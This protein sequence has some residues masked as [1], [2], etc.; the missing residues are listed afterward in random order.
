MKVTILTVGS[1]GDVQ[2]FI[3][4]GMGL[5][6]AGHEVRFCTSHN[7]EPFV[8][9]HGLDYA[10]MDD[11][12]IQLTESPEARAAMEKGGNPLGLIKKVKPMIKKM[13]YDQW[14]AVQGTEAIIYHPKTL[15]GYHLM[16]KLNVPG[17]MAIFVPAYTPTAEF[18]NP[19]LTRFSLGGWFNKLTYKLM[20]LVQAPYM[21]VV[22][23]WRQ[24]ALGLSPRSR[25]AGEWERH[26]GRPVPT[27]YA[28]SRYLVP[29]PDDWP[30]TAVVTG[31]WF[32][33][34]QETWQPPAALRHFLENGPPPV[35]VGFGSIGGTNP[36]KT[37]QIVLDALAQSGQRGILASGWGGLTASD[38]PD[39]V[40]KLEA[41]P[42]D[43]L[44]PR[45]AA[46]VHHG[47][48]GTTAAGLRAGKPTIIC[49]FFG[50]QPFWGKQVFEM[51]LGPQPIAQKKLTVAALAT[52]IDTAVTD[53]EMGRRAA[54]IG[55]K[56][57]NENGVARAIEFI[58]QT[59]A[60]DQ[61]LPVP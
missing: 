48:S 25:F 23:K 5:Q 17:F 20:P 44:F 26:D 6:K 21:D 50:D 38:L 37:T 49:P 31:T 8:R 42:H 11:E 43:W 59:I 27:L 14:D 33:P 13:L 51:G 34:R 39:S 41:A 60:S 53:E 36:E 18:P 30:Q 61:P 15:G 4:L 1:R 19:I 46:V 52:A 3:A 54:E 28:F 55:Q 16:E 2:P 22:N 40:F 56:I 47:G 57:R 32:L 10:Y 12:M 45:V 7:F 58:Q 35:Y 29:P 9:E 24:E